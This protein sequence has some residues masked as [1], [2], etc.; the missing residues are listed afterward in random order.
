MN[1]IMQHLQ[2]FASSTLETTLGDSDDM[3]VGNYTSVV[4]LTSYEDVFFDPLCSNP[5][6]EYARLYVD[7]MLNSTD[8][9]NNPSKNPNPDSDDFDIFY[10]SAKQLAFPNT[11]EIVTTAVGG[12]K[13]VYVTCSDFDETKDKL[14]TTSC[15]KISEVE[16]FPGAKNLDG[17]FKLNSIKCESTPTVT[18]LSLDECPGIGYWDTLP[19][20]TI[21]IF[22]VLL[23][24]VCCCGCC[25]MKLCC[26][27]R[28]R[29]SGGYEGYGASQQQQYHQYMPPQQQQQQQ[30]EY[31][32][33]EYQQQQQKAEPTWV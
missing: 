6:S 1:S 33:Q 12:Y 2:H 4:G 20:V 28:K 17:Y 25:C 3:H 23:G 27:K 32:Q 18:N 26:G 14:D 5:S 9:L 21:F 22:V 10:C 16:K 8:W 30:Q 15:L 29:Q 24:L 31:Q 13:N 19:D 11:Y 7:A